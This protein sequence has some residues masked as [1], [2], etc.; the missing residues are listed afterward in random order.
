MQAVTYPH[1]FTFSFCLIAFLLNFAMPAGAEVYR[2]VDS[3]GKTHYGDR[4]P[5]EPRAKAERMSIQSSPQGLD[6]DA[7]RN[8]QQMRLIEEGRQRERA[9][10]EQKAAQNQQQGAELA[11]RCRELQNEIREDRDVAVF[12]RYDEKGNRVLWTHEERLAHREQLSALKQTYCPDL[13]H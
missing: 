10:A 8:R 2:W 12:F 6:P 11:R 3:E 1:K 5:Q 4:A 9:F 13:P 7:E